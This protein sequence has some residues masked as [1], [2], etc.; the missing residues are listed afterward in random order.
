MARFSS[1][2]GVFFGP[3]RSSQGLRNR[4]ELGEKGR[5]RGKRSFLDFQICLIVGFSI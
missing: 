3:S 5:N 2:S 1:G 4:G